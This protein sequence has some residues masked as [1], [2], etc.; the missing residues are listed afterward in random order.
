MRGLYLSD[1]KLSG[2]ITQSIC[3]LT[4]LEAIFLDENQL[5]GGIP[6][7]IGNLSKLQ[8]LHLF[9]NK[10]SGEIPIDAMTTLR[11][12]DSLGLENNSGLQGD[13]PED[14]CDKSST[15]IEIWAD[16]GGGASAAVSCPCCS[17]CCPS[18]E[19]I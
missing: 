15:P 11:E 2:T 14:F 3:T 4:S 8:Q 19:C 7:C 12:L 18:D 16:C 6:E 13:I 17:V 10:L 5:E 9:N 1:N